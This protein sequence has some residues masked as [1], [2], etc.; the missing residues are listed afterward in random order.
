MANDV[1][2]ANLMKITIL[3]EAGTSSEKMDLTP[4]PFHFE[5]I[6]GV[7]TEGMTPFEYAILDKPVGETIVL[8]LDRSQLA[9]TFGHIDL[10]VLRLV[11]ADSFFL[12]AVVENV[13]KPEDWEVVKA[14]AAAGG[15][16]DECGGGC[17]CG[18]SC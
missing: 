8:K 16:S 17:D 12:K 11:D 18:C 2:V 4:A 13:V 5:F 7:A 1:K 15:C 14:M 10:P 6:F 9:E 3:V